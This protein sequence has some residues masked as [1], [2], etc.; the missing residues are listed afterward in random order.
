MSRTP[1]SFVSSVE[2]TRW[3]DLMGI[4]RFL[5][6]SALMFVGWMVGLSAAITVVGL[7]LGLA[8]MALGLELMVGSRSSR[9]GRTSVR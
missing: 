7:P 4:L 5:V 9:S 6:G 8:V 3:E 1:H 2:R